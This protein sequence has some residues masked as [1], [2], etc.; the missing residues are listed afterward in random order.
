MHRRLFLMAAHGLTLLSLHLALLLGTHTAAHAQAPPRYTVSA[1][2]LQQLVAQQ[3]PRRYP[4][5][6]LMRMDVQAPALRL[7][8]QLNRL[9]A[10]MAVEAAG[11]LLGRNQKGM[12][13]VDFALRY[14]ASDSTIRAHQLR[15]K[16]LRMDDLSSAGTELLNTYAPALAE[17]TLQEVVLHQLRPQDLARAEDLG[18]QPSSITVTEAGLVI[19]FEVKPLR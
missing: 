18:L 11:P 3:F 19:G 17:Q 10:E 4:V 1:A 16:R 13:E 5:A 7:L 15:F 8:P 14:E 2:Q 9:S 6:G 12:F